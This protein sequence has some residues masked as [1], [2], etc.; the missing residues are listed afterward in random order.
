MATSAFEALKQK[1]SIL[2]TQP[3]QNVSA[4]D[5]LKQKV[6]T[7]SLP[8][9]APK[10]GVINSITNPSPENA[11]VSRDM[12][13]GEFIKQNKAKQYAQAFVNT[14]PK[15]AIDFFKYIP[16][17]MA[18]LAVSAGELP[19]QVAL[20]KGQAMGTEYNLP[21]IGKVKS[22]QTQAQEAIGT[23]RESSDIEKS[24]FTP[25]ARE[26]INSD[27]P[28]SVRS[29]GIPVLKTISDA[30][31]TSGALKSGVNAARNLVGDVN[32]S[33]GEVTPGL[34]EKIP[35]V[36][37]KEVGNVKSG[38]MEILKKNAID[39]WVKPAKTPNASYNKATDIYNGALDRGHDIGE[40]LVNDG[41]KQSEHV[42]G[43]RFVTYET[44]Q[45]IR[46][47]AGK[48]SYQ[49]LRP[50]LEAASPSVPY[51]PVDDVIRS[52]KKSIGSSQY[53]LPEDKLNLLE[54]LDDL[55]PVLQTKYPD[56]LSL[57][58]IH[59]ERIL[60]DINAKY[61]PIG[62]IAVNQKA[63]IN[64]T[65]A[66]T[67][68]DTLLKITPEDIPVA[69]FQKELQK[70]Y[71]AASYLEQLDTKSVPKGVLSKIANTGA[72]VAGAAAGSHLG[73]GGIMGG[74]GG[75]HIGGMVENVLNDL[76]A[77][78]RDSMLI[79]LE[80]TNPEVFNQVKDVI[81]KMAQT[82]ATR[83]ALPSPG[84]TTQNAI[85]LPQP[86]VLKGQENIRSMVDIVENKMVTD[87]EKLQ[88]RL[89]DIVGYSS[90]ENALVNTNPKIA[91]KILSIKP[92]SEVINVN[93]LE[94]KI[95]SILTATEEKI[96]NSDI[97]RT[98]NDMRH[99][100]SLYKK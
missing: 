57:L 100:I 33:T 18:E 14:L 40:T 16:Q 43:G 12:T 7:T 62:D 78:A 24:I 52:A 76:P 21:I 15:D 41:I 25:K 70:Q 49:T 72:R 22:L 28:F 71:E 68:R 92:S 13:G 69:E 54:N 35:G 46:E 59:D 10:K 61:S 8:P 47:D 11:L 88:G 19:T 89:H 32:L 66:D 80:K 55:N 83:L 90:R 30:A 23:P 73:G 42:Q 50:A 60:R 2:K 51:T 5:T 93:D 20:N 39:N 48:L 29:L 87:P 97:L 82:Q 67:L 58:D 75:Y 34:V 44:A 99:T 17:A 74:V 86:G 31:I 96:A 81:G 94:K 3:A 1:Q 37:K 26:V 38:G 77:Q 98:L 45:Q 56:G 95:R 85:P 63:Q 65:L 6:G 4:F 53:I 27:K 36:I 79:N 84:T 9:E 91:K 64:K